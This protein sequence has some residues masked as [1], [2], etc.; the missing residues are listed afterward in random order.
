MSGPPNFIDPSAGPGA[1]AIVPARRPG[2]LAGKVIGLLDNTKEQSDIILEAI[3][4][5][6]CERHGVARIVTRR[7]EHYSRQAPDRLIEELAQEVDI[8]ACALGG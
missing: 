6:L 3:G 8:A 2:T 1:Q 5:A 7:K 4:E